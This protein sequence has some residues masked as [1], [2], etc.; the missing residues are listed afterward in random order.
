MRAS[1]EKMSVLGWNKSSWE[2][3]TN[4]VR[5]KCKWG[6]RGYPYTKEIK[7]C[8]D[9]LMDK[10]MIGLRGYHMMCVFYVRDVFIYTPSYKGRYPN[11]VLSEHNLGNN[12]KNLET[13]LKHRWELMGNYPDFK[14]VMVIYHYFEII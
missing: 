12:Y 4:L 6:T 8:A 1:V 7:I 3:P 5:G 13:C 9:N 10:V 14:V 2:E 11:R